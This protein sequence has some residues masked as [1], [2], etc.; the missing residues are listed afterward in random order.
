MP[1][2]PEGKLLWGV[3]LETGHQTPPIWMQL[4]MASFSLHE[5]CGYIVP[6]LILDPK[7]SI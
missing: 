1:S 4:E 5:H 7:N 3:T 6:S 2:L